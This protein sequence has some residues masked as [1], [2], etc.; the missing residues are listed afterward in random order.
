MNLTFAEDFTSTEV[1][2]AQLI[3]TP[4]SGLYWNRGVHPVL[5][6]SN[7]LAFLPNVTFTFTAWSNSA[8]Y[9]V[10]ETS[11]KRTDVVTRK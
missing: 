11:R 3:A 6:V 9:G 8:T 5:T 7:L 1:L 10:F 4:D 2:D